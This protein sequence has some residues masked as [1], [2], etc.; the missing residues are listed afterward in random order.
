MAKIGT[1]YATSRVQLWC[2]ALDLLCW[3][4][5]CGPLE[6]SFRVALDYEQ[7]A[8]TKNYDFRSW[9]SIFPAQNI[10]MIT[11]LHL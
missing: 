1:E 8:A 9:C 10:Y 6:L 7:S 11:F 4:A 5:K 3:I 2:S